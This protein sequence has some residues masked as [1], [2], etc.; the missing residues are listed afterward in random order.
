MSCT[1]RGSWKSWGSCQYNSGSCGAGTRYRKRSCD[2]PAP[3]HGG[4]ACAGGDTD[5]TGCNTCCPTNGSWSAWGGFGGCNF[6]SGSCGAGTKTRTR[7][8]SG[9]SCGGSSCSGSSQ[10]SQACSTCCPVNGSWGRWSGWS[11]CVFKSGNCG[12]GTKTRTRTCSGQACGGSS[13]AG[14]SSDSTSC[15]TACYTPPPPIVWPGFSITTM[16]VGEEGGGISIP[17]VKPKPIAYGGSHQ[18]LG[19]MGIYHMK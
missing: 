7:T 17:V 3:A 11:S 5:N 12:A 4:N 2:N 13:C 15:S 9:Q 16:A 8:C 14:S 19:G 10:D 18:K 1:S 6:N